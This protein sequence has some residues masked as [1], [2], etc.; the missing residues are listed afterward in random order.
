MKLRIAELYAQISS[1]QTEL[2]SIREK[3]K[4]DNGYRIMNYQW[5]IGSIYPSRICE[6]C[7]STIPGIAQEE[8]DKFLTEEKERQKEWRKANGISEEGI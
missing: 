8:I 6:D 7:D 3:C 1:A 4:H 5:R 2:Q